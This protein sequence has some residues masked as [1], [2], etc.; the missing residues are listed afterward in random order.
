MKQPQSCRHA[1]EDAGRTNIG[2]EQAIIRE[3][4]NKRDRRERERG[5]GCWMRWGTAPALRT[6][7]CTCVMP[8]LE[9]DSRRLTHDT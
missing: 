8:H 9:R 1:L 5:L 6:A 4:T 7:V 3:G 2:P